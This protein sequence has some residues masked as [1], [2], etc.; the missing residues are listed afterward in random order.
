VTCSEAI[1]IPKN[2]EILWKYN[3]WFEPKECLSNTQLEGKVV[4]SLSINQMP[5]NF[6]GDS[7]DPYGIK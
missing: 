4:F 6:I 2:C 5:V 3:P 1:L 7:W